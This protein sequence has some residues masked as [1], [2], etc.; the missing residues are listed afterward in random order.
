M[1]ELEPLNVTLDKDGWIWM[2][3]ID[4]PSQQLMVHCDNALYIINYKVI[5]VRTSCGKICIDEV[6]TKI[7]VY[8]HGL[9]RRGAVGM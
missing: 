2:L 4:I 9:C 5:R 3:K 8:R 1:K 6:R 7:I